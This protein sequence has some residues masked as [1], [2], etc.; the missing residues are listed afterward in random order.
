MGSAEA[1]GGLF[2][3]RLHYA[4]QIFKDFAVPESQHG[5]AFL[6]QKF[7]AGCVIGGSIAVLRTIE[8]DGQSRRA[9][10]KIDDIRSDH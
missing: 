7:G 6:F 5:P 2:Q 9:A 4:V 10:C 1:L 3:N 8:F